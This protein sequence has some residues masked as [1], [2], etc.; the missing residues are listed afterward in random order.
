MT[1]LFYL[2]TINLCYYNIFTNNY[3]SCEN[4]IFICTCTYK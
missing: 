2:S 1:N 4:I 3:I